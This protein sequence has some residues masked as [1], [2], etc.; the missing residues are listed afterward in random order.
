M[1]L[2][3]FSMAHAGPAVPPPHHFVDWSAPLTV[4]TP[5]T[6]VAMIVESRDEE[7]VSVQVVADGTLFPA[8]VTWHKGRVSVLVADVDHP[9]R[10]VR[11]RSPDARRITRLDADLFLPA[12]PEARVQ[13][14]APAPP[15]AAG[16]LPSELVA[17]G[18]TSR[19]DWDADPT[20]C[21]ST[22]DDWY[23]MAIHHTAG[24][25][26]YGG[27]VQG[28]VQALQAYSLG[29]GEY[30]DIP[31]QFLVG[32]DGSLWEGRPYDYYSGATGGG[33]NDGNIAV[34]FLGC[35]HPS[36]CGG[37]SN[38]VTDEMMDGGQLLVQTLVALDSIPSDADSIRGH[39]DWPDNATAC[40]GDW[41]YDRLDELR[42]PLGP[43]FAG[44]L[45]AQS[46]APE[47]EGAFTLLP[48]ETG[49]CALELVNTGRST[50]TPGSTNLAPIPRDV[51]SPL[52]AASWLDPTRI[53][54]VE[55]DT[56]PGATGRFAFDVL[57]P[58]AGE[59]TLSLG[60]VEEWVTWFADDGGPADGE[61][62]VALNVVAAEADTGA[63][64][65]GVSP[66]SAG[67]L[68]APGRLVSMAEIGECGCQSSEGGADA[69]I[70]WLAVALSV[71]GRRS[72]MLGAPV[73]DRTGMRGRR[74]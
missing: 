30:C 31:Y 71:A 53:V 10:S 70:G 17:I 56:A 1:L 57:A 8:A 47:A 48:G 61:M 18:V 35:Y 7:P 51:A 24:T 25:Q 23:R 39:R 12:E 43:S 38:S 74:G 63:P 4:D 45:T 42:E 64:D 46:C 69:A 27:T 21:T 29:T 37:G 59:Y 19:A 65:P 15:P 36:G 5:G 33:N 3:S 66:D 54:S 16:V 73:G 6:R 58:A 44:S 26:T 14:G 68:D 52:A 60:L 55:A 41:L 2:L 34:C 62:V 50:W 40:P 32:Y 67:A 28:T 22:E 49:Q 20:T 72:R 13:A 9:T 11:L